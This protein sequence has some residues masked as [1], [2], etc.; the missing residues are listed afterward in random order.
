[1]PIITLM[2]LSACKHVDADRVMLP[3]MWGK[4]LKQPGVFR[5]LFLMG[6]LYAGLS[7]VAGLLTFLPFMDSMAEAYRIASVERSLDP[8]L[9]AMRVPLTI[10]AIIYVVIACAVLACA[11]AGGLAWPAPDP[12]AVLLRHRLLAQQMA[13]PG[14]RRHVGPGV[15]VHRPVCRLAGH[16]GLVAPICRHLANPF[17]I[18]AGGVLYC[19]FY[20]AYTS[21]FGIDRATSHL[22]NGHSAEA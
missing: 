2:T 16:D 11:S 8:I 3:S 4:P 15:P 10:F 20:P 5:K 12:G 9:M 7:M 21:V 14:V 17:N 18:A 1:M 19:S 13:L 22:D 6:L